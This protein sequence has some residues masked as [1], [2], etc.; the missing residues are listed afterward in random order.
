MLTV[1]KLDGFDQLVLNARGLPANRTF[2]VEGIRRDGKGT[3]VISIRADA[4]VSVDQALAYTRFLGVYKRAVLTNANSRRTA[5]VATYHVFCEGWPVGP[6]R[7]ATSFAS[8]S[9]RE[10]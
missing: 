6:A 8:N 2:T 10:R 5:S 4:R 7:E 3:P 1:R 9:A